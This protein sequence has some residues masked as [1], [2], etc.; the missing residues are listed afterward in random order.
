MTDVWDLSAYVELHPEDYPQR[1]RLAKKLFAEK[2]YRLAL[3]HLLVL[4]NSWERKLTVERYLA[5]TFYRLGRYVEAAERL[6]KTIE[7]WPDEIGPR[8]QLAHVLRVDGDLKGSL[9]V[10][11]GILELQPDHAVAQ[12][13]VKKLEEKIA[14]SSTKSA[15][16]HYGNVHLDLVTESGDD[17]FVSGIICPRCGVQNSEE[18]ETCWQCNANLKLRTPSFLNTPPIEAHGPYLLQPETLASFATIIIIVFLLAAAALAGWHYMTYTNENLPPLLSTDDLGVRVL[19]PARLTMGLVLLVCWPFLLSSVLRL[20]RAKPYPPQVLTYLAG[21][22]LSSLNLVMLMLPMP[23]PAMSFFVTLF[24]SLGIIL[25]TFRIY[26][27][28][29]IAVW[30]TQFTLAW[31]LGLLCFWMAESKRYGELINPFVEV[32]A[33]GAALFGDNALPDAF[34]TRLP[35]TLTPFRQKIRWASSGS[36]WL[37]AHAGQV[38]LTIQP[39]TAVPELRFQIFEEEEMKYHENI[40]TSQQRTVDI[41][42]IPGPIYEVVVLGE[43]NYSVPITLQSLLPFEFLNP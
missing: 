2:E 35:R 19:F 8:E 22:F 17:I 21:F 28:L 26:T 10:W 38:R 7:Q 14:E 33:I 20:F 4:H 6:R 13:A 27:S 12:R 41:A 15:T 18:F 36:N 24:L 37:D 30:I 25:F 9:E 29:A 3:E 31:T 32:P 11:R 5:A 1:W 23:F 16:P 34:P 43:T 40:P 39:E 42:I